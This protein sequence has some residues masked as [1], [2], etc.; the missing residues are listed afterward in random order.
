MR[1]TRWL[2]TGLFTALTTL[3]LVVLGSIAASIDAHSREHALDASVDRVVTGVA[4]EVYWDENGGVD[5]EVV[6]ADDDLVA[7]ANAISILVRQPDGGWQELFVHKRSALPVELDGL[8]QRAAA[9]EITQWHTTTDRDGHPVRLAAA[10]A[11]DNDSSVGAIV[12]VG[13]D[14]APGAR[15]H[16]RLVVALWGG[17]LALVALAAL[18]GHLLSGAS[19]RPAL[20]MLDEQER[21]LSEASHELRTPLTTLRLYL[22]AALRDPADARRAVTDA[23]SL[24]DRMGRMVAGLLARTR[25]ETG[26][27]ELDR[28]RLFLDQLVEGVVAEC[29]GDV[30]VSTEPTAVCADPDLLA[31]AVR[32]LIDNALVHGHPPVEVRVAAGRV[33]VCD[34]GPGLDPALTDPFRRGAMGAG[35][36]HGIGLSLVQWVATVHSGSVT[37]AP[38]PGGGTLA[39]LTLPVAPD[40]AGADAPELR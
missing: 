16:R 10:P 9:A 4:R 13:G 5:L 38:A 2:L 26:A 34:H 18:A 6:R 29:S 3:C 28:Q 27:G 40:D 24:T 15:D 30:T 21:F 17:G 14:P 32:N 39:T 25:A 31:L 8:A 33:T 36:R 20:R 1:R 23:R 37:L 35:G 19:M 11:W 12:F 22:D 7:G